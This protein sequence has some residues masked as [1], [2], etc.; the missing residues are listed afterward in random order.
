MKRH[1]PF[2][3]RRENPCFQSNSTMSIPEKTLLMKRFKKASHHNRKGRKFPRESTSESGS[4]YD[5]APDYSHRLK[6]T[7]P[8]D[9][10]NYQ[11]S[12][13]SLPLPPPPNMAYY[14]YSSDSGRGSRDNLTDDA[15]HSFAIFND[16]NE[17]G[18]EDMYITNEGK[19]IENNY[20]RGNLVKR[21]MYL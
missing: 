8:K 16:S 3:N 18:F 6:L 20:I 21:N 11:W 19:N 17:D 13:D 7:D 4:S 10:H 15:H 2:Y 12:E 1:H 14:Y 9:T 5:H